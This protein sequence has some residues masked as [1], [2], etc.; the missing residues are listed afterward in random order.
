MMSRRLWTYLCAGGGG[1]RLSP[2]PGPGT[3]DSADPASV[4]RLQWAPPRAG[5]RGFSH[6]APSVRESPQRHRELCK[7]VSN[8][9][10]PRAPLLDILEYQ[11]SKGD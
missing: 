11:S 8:L 7:K 3:P 1:G 4:L 2:R 9:L 6:S 10:V 5:P